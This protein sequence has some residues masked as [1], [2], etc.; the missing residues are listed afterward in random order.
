MSP[1]FMVSVPISDFPEVLEASLR[2][3]APGCFVRGPGADRPG[4]EQRQLPLLRDILGE[5][6]CG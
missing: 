1:V 3:C 2:A 4:Y 5:E 6:R